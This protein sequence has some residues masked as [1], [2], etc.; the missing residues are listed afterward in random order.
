M[1]IAPPR[2]IIRLDLSGL[3]VLL[4]I[5]QRYRCW[6]DAKV[7]FD[8]NTGLGA[9]LVPGIAVLLTCIGCDSAP[10]IPTAV[11][12]D[13]SAVC[14]TIEGFGA[15]GAYDAAELAA[16][17]Q[18]KPEIY[19]WLFGTPASGQGLGLDIFRIKNTYQHPDDTNLA[20]IGTI[21][22]A[23]RARNP[24]LKTELVS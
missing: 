4:D 20:A 17:G 1:W 9:G 24:D 7:A 3:D 5:E 8:M 14:Q 13:Y 19:D 22:E 16:F 15:A 6:G 2:P 11:V 23:G 10:P 18:A 12:V 21:L